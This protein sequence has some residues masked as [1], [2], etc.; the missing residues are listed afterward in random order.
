[1]TYI[2]NFLGEL[3]AQLSSRPAEI[4]HKVAYFPQDPTKESERFP[5]TD[6]DKTINYDKWIDSACG[7]FCLKMIL[8]TKQNKEVS[9]I[10][11][12]RQAMD[13]GIYKIDEDQRLS[14]ML[15]E[16]F[17]KFIKDK[18]GIKSEVCKYLSMNRIKYELSKDNLVIASVHWDIKDQNRVPPF[19]G[20]HLVVVTGYQST[21]CFFINNPS[22]IE[23]VSQVDYKISYRNFEKF[24][25]K[26][27]IIIMN[28]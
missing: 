16:P 4:H 7:M 13:Y 19:K 24:F 18:F 11:P 15:Y 5:K 10:E 20:G 6:F 26:R 2:K 27:G 17:A 9:V 25:A 14:G 3:K 22:G 12:V 21:G 28:N 1:M 23:K 8:K